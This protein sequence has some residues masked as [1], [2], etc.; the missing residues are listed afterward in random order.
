MYLYG[1]HTPYTVS[2]GV[3][4]IAV[5]DFDVD[6]L[7]HAYFAR[8]EALLRDIYDLMR[9]GEAPGRRQRIMPAVHDG[10]SFWKLIR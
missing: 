2:P 3:D 5:P 8:A 6:L 4:T 10:Q 1:Y 7:G 9:H